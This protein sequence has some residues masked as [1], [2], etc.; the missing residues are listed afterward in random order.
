MAW[1]G[2]SFEIGGNTPN[3]SQVR[4]KIFLGNPPIEGSSALLIKCKRIGNS[5]IFSYGAIIKI[6]PVGTG[7][8]M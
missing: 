6:D 1:P 8:E 3:A 7:I 2:V 5:C 4:K